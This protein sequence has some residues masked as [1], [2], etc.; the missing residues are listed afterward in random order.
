VNYR[1]LQ[2]ALREE[3]KSFAPGAAIRV[4]RQRFVLAWIITACLTLVRAEAS[5]GGSDSG[6]HSEGAPSVATDA[7]IVQVLGVRSSSQADRSEVVIDL[8]ANVR[9]KVGHLSDPLRLYLNLSQTR[10]ST[11]LT[12]RRIPLKDD[13]VDQIR[14]GADQSSVTRIVLDLHTA[15]HSRVS[16]LGSPARLL[17]ELSP[18]DEAAVPERGVAKRLDVQDVPGQVPAGVG[19]TRSLAY[20]ETWRAKDES[21]LSSNAELSRAKSAS[22]PHPYGDGEKAKLNFDGVSPTRNILALGLNAGSSYDDNI[23]GNNQRRVGD[24]AFQFGPSL[25]VRREGQRLSFALSYRPQFRIYRKMSEQ[26]EVDQTLGFDAG[27]K[28]SSRLSFRARTSAFSTT[29][30]FQP[31]QNEESLPGLGSPASLNN[32]VF[33]PTA[34]QLT[35]SS[36]LDASYQAGKHDLVGIFAG[37]SKLD[38]HQQLSNAGSIQNTE[39]KDASLVYQHRLSRHTTVGIDYQYKDIRFGSDSR[40]LVHSAFFS[41]A[42]QVSPSLTLSVF[43]GPQ[44]S[45]LNEVII[46]PLGPFTLRVPVSLPTSNWALGGTLTKQLDK[47]AFQL[48]AQHQVS[49]G[50]GL[51]GAVVSSSAG[52]S[53]RRRLPGRWDA[54]G[55]AS[56]A[57]NDSLDT[58]SSRGAYQSLTAGVGLGHS[59]TEKLS[60]RVGYDFIHQR[61]TGPSQLFA[62]FDRDLWSV[63]FFYGFHEIALGR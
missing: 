11:Q 14:I 33:T 6:S 59:L 17:V 23:L 54:I 52:V 29:G 2:I 57:N 18:P 51:L 37:R 1:K 30:I 47:T 36:R 41:Y 15:V 35:W 9:Y 10:I 21:S 7:A 48:T 20:G 16:Q 13:L 56:Y 63:Q 25:N 49:D 55:S 53:A 38:F 58:T 39:Q 19:P 42:R 28:V 44:F 22:G 50:G 61:G 31:N 45:H 5:L 4:A 27:Y 40:T 60:V 8:S 62:D 32:T 24:V 3:T 43:G 12:T 26:N 34:R 46:F